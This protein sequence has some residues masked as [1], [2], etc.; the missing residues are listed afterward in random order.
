MSNWRAR[1]FTR[2][3]GNFK[4]H[5][6]EEIG[7]CTLFIGPNQS[8]KSGRIIGGRYALGGTDAWSAGK[9]GSAIA[10]AFAPPGVDRLFH[11]FEGPDGRAIFEVLHHRGAWREPTPPVFT[12]G[13]ETINM[14]DRARVL[15]MVAMADLLTFGETKGRRA[16]VARFGLGLGNMEPDDIQVTADD[17]DLSKAVKVQLRKL[18]EEAWNECAR[19]LTTPVKE[20]DA[21][22]K[23]APDPTEVLV[24]V[25]KF[26]RAQKERHGK[27]IV[28]LEAAIA[29]RKAKL[30]AQAAGSEMLPQLK[31]QRDRALEWEKSQTARELQAQIERDKAAYRARALPF[32]EADARK[33]ETAA[34]RAAERKTLEDAVAAARGVVDGLVADLRRFELNLLK[35]ANPLETSV[36]AHLLCTQPDFI[37][38]EKDA[39]RDLESWV[40]LATGLLNQPVPP[41]AHC[42]L[43]VRAGFDTIGTI[44]YL[45][46]AIAERRESMAAT[47]RAIEVAQEKLNEANKALS[48]WDG[49][50][51]QRTSADEQARRDLTQE[52]ARIMASEAA[53]KKAFEGQKIPESYSGP[54][55]AELQAHIDLLEQA[56]VARKELIENQEAV[57]KVDKKRAQAKAF[58]EAAVEILQKILIGVQRTAEDTVSRYMPDGLRAVLDLDKN[59]WAVMDTRVGVPRSKHSGSGWELDA[60]APALACGFTEG[61]PLRVLTLDDPDLDGVG[62][63]NAVRFFA[64]LKRTVDAGHLTQV[65]AA[66][67]RFEPVLGEIMALGWKV[68]RVDAVE[69][70]APVLPIP[71]VTP[72]PGPIPLPPLPPIG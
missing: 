19:A 33:E 69:A 6:N 24:A 55:S 9:H 17:D 36:R 47:R 65:L 54:S 71:V 34:A 42:P 25:S 12:D 50:Q 11:E 14:N 28:A 49:A 2:H 30:T 46:G 44:Q 13:L 32:Q 68:I 63:E 16:I 27:E 60:L 59:S 41:G 35:A 56:D 70:P 8:G 38:P 3:R 4:I 29:E 1:P 43:C 10:A 58:E 21:N 52:H 20:R 61:A 5:Y 57:R 72:A 66:G 31:A 7:P 26:F 40:G 23:T 48:T 15:P 37:F 51:Q 39:A 62:L 45:L 18:W 22:G 64:S 53:A 67:N